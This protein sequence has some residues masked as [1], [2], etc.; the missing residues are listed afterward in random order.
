MRDLLE[1]CQDGNRRHEFNK[2][3]REHR[4]KGVFLG[5]GEILEKR[6]E[7][8]VPC[9]A[10]ERAIRF[11]IELELVNFHEY[12]QYRKG[13]VLPPHI[14]RIQQKCAQAIIREG[15]MPVPNEIFE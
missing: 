2:K 15:V 14:T 7:V 3:L 13:R 11:G 12:K 5:P 4:K 1:I 6:T 10:G 9:I 8:I